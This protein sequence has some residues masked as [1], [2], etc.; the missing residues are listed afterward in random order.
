MK[1]TING[2][3]QEKLIEHGLDAQDA[4]L[5]DWLSDLISSPKIKTV[6]HD[7]FIYYWIKYDAVLEDLPI[8]TVK[9]TKGIG[10]KFLE[11]EAKGLLVKRIVRDINGSFSYFR[12][13]DA[14]HDM[15]RSESKAKRHCHE[16]SSATEQEKR[17]CPEKGYA[18]CPEKG[19]PLPQKEQ[20]Y[21]PPTIY[22]PTKENISIAQQ[23]E[24]EPRDKT[25]K[26]ILAD[27]GITGQVAKDFLKVRKAKRSPLTVTAM[28]GI[29]N[30]AGKAGITVSDAITICAKKGWQGFNASWN[31][32]EQKSLGS[33]TNRN[34]GSIGTKP[35]TRTIPHENFADKDYGQSTITAPWLTGT[36]IN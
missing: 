33:A 27:Y 34:Q 19:N 13:T 36:G 26:E 10:K 5:L 20:S 28:E 16:K 24:K 9:N 11:L 35:T 22:P 21:N 1:F 14:V 12:F 25:E 8:L 7:G 15:K 6:Q 2:F 32:Q 23:E 17:H 31:W 30:E 29:S 18:H 3:S 4:L